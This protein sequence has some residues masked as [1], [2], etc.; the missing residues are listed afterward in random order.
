MAISLNF[1]ST[2]ESATIAAPT[3]ADGDLMIATFTSDDSEPPGASL[4][5]WTT[6]HE[7]SH[8]TS[9]FS[10]QTLYKV[11][12]SES[13]SYNFGS[14]TQPNNTLHIFRDS[15]GGGTW[16]FPDDSTS[17]GASTS[18]STTS[19]VAVLTD[20]MLLTMWGNDGNRT[21]STSPSGMTLGNGA[22][23]AG[24]ALYGYYQLIT[25]D[26]PTLTKSL[27]W[28][29]DEQFIAGAIVIRYTGGGGG[30][31]AVPTAVHNYRQRRV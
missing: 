2:A 3:V 5:G 21:V 13:G 29:A 10:Y 27:V 26:D 22:T 30:G 6:L 18:T 15:A 16:S 28:S 11:A 24:Q 25:S 20:D 4:T 7:H 17:E 31:L 19:A 1:S 12:S 8:S 9:V 14:V 23:T